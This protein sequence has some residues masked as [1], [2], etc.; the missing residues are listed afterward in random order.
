ML[1]SIVQQKDHNLDIVVTCSY[2][3]DG[4]DGQPNNIQIIDFFQNKGLNIIGY[5]YPQNKMLDRTYLRNDR[6]KNTKADWILF[7]DCDMIYDPLFFTDLEKK[8]MSDEYKN[9]TKVFGADRVSLDID[10]CEKFLLDYQFIDPF[11][12]TQPA[13]QIKD[14]PYFNKG[15]RS[16]AA[17]YFQLVNGDAIRNLGKYSVK[18][19]GFRGDGSIRYLSGGVVGLDLKPQYH[20]NHHRNDRYGAKFQK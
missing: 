4:S 13:E 18:N 14:F 12:I 10:L 2:L 9:I 7:A 1:S 8:L 11:F 15:G 17:G 5:E 6:A 16:R 19:N 3:K 20:L